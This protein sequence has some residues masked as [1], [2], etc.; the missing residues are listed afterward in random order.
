ML[1]H[2]FCFLLSHPKNKAWKKINPVFSE[3]YFCIQKNQII[4][5]LLLFRKSLIPDINFFFWRFRY[6]L[7]VSEFENP[8]WFHQR[9]HQLS[10]FFVN[11]FF[12][13]NCKSPLNQIPHT[14][15]STLF[16]NKTLLPLRQTISCNRYIIFTNLTNCSLFH[17]QPLSY[18]TP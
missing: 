18:L 8:D 12:D 17:P 9:R 2:K 15:H 10:F 4:S 5:R 3:N 7:G 1:K 6:C 11:F 14:T 13:L 16:Y